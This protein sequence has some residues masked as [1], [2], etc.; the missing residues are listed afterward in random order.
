M[1]RSSRANSRDWRLGFQWKAAG[2][3]ALP[4]TM[5]ALLIKPDLQ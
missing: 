3:K 5:I 1:Q 2:E 4:P